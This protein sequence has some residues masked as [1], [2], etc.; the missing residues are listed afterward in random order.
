MKKSYGRKQMRALA[1][2]NRRK[3]G[4]ARAKA[5]ELAQKKR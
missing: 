3:E 1:R 2:E 4:R 5:N